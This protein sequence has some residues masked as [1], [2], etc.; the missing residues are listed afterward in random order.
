MQAARYIA[1][2]GGFFLQGTQPNT[3]RCIF[4]SR[5]VVRSWICIK[6]AVPPELMYEIDIVCYKHAVP[7]GLTSVSPGV[8]VC[9]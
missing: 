3:Y 7:P 4:I 9:L 6:H 5:R 8:A 2:T 1:V